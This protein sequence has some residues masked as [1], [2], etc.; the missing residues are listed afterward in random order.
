MKARRR[1]NATLWLVLF[2]LLIITSPIWLVI[3]AGLLAPFLIAAFIVAIP[4]G[5][6]YNAIKK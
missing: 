6:I 5:V 3:I 2:P 1:D 4:A